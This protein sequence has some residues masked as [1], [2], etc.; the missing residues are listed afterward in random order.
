MD[1]LTFLSDV[2]HECKIK[3]VLHSESS[4]YYN[5]VNFLLCYPALGVTAL[6]GSSFLTGNNFF[7]ESS[8]VLKI[9]GILNIV[10]CLVLVVQNLINF[11]KISGDHLQISREYSKLYREIVYFK[12]QSSSYPYNNFVELFCNNVHFRLNIIMEVELNCPDNIMKSIL[13]EKNE[14]L[15]EKYFVAQTKFKKH[16][17]TK[18]HVRKL[19]SMDR[20]RLMEIIVLGLRDEQNEHKYPYMN[21]FNASTMQLMDFIVV[22]LNVDPKNISK[23]SPSIE[24]HMFSNPIPSIR[25]DEL[26]G[27]GEHID[28]IENNSVIINMTGSSENISELVDR[29]ST[30]SKISG[31]V[32]THKKNKSNVSTASSVTRESLNENDENNDSF[33]TESYRKFKEELEINILSY[34]KKFKKRCGKCGMEC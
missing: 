9:F 14:V 26:V 19:Y 2:E 15:T 1:P 3:S 24:E 8:N 28:N 22:E 11:T 10:A 4:S 7:S 33:D 29:A 16:K 13:K 23:E 20:G 27:I 18:S 17:Y 34:Y 31:N 32:L 12:K 21:F 6:C 30:S 5:K 25:I